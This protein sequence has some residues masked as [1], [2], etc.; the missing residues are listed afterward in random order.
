LGLDSR[1]AAQGAA[2]EAA[3]VLATGPSTRS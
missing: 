3:R 2:R 1:A